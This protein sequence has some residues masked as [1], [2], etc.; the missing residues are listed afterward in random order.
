M[1]NEDTGTVT[2]K[3]TDHVQMKTLQLDYDLSQN[4]KLQSNSNNNKPLNI[5][6]FNNVAVYSKT[7]D[8]DNDDR[9]DLNDI[10]A[11]GPLV[12]SRAPY[13][14]TG[15]VELSALF[16]DILPPRNRRLD[17]IPASLSKCAF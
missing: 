5:I 15:A 4:G 14:T 11:V 6:F 17:T 3:M 12:D 13:S 9:D 10:V 1:E 7:N 8:D 2:M 16:D